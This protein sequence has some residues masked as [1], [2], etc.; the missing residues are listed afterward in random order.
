MAELADQILEALH[1]YA[2]R[3]KSLDEFLNWFVPVSS[4]V[5]RSGE[6]KAIHVANYIDGILAEASSAN[7]NEEEIHEELASPFVGPRFGQNRYGDVPN[8]SVAQSNAESDAFNLAA[9]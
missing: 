6:P 8:S 1:D 9:A 2:E 7:W 5:E 4:N 3:K